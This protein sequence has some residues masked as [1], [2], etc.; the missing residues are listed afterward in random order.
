VRSHD[1]VLLFI[2]STVEQAPTSDYGLPT[3][4]VDAG[5]VVLGDAVTAE[6]VATASELVIGRLVAGLVSASAG[7]GHGNCI[8]AAAAAAAAPRAASDDEFGGGTPKA[9]ADELGG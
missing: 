5:E 1:L 9:A 4:A 6:R 2:L 8:A 3:D 7:S